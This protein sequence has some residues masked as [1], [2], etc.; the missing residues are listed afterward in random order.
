MKCVYILLVMVL[1]GCVGVGG[2]D[3]DG[4]GICVS[5]D[6]GSEIAVGDVIVIRNKSGLDVY[7][8]GHW[9][10]LD[11]STDAADVPDGEQAEIIVPEPEADHAPIWRCGTS[12]GTSV[13]EWSYTE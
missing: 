13:R 12:D 8:D 3:D 4:S 6:P 11:P 9:R 7:C 10:P 5:P 1:G 2:L